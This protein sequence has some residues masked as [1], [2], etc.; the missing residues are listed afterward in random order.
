MK[1]QWEEIS[2]SS[3]RLSLT[4]RAKVYGGWLIKCREIWDGNGE[5]L[6]LVF[7]PDPEHKWSIK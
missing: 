3:D 6:S 7:M 1:F 2:Q 4:L 5:C